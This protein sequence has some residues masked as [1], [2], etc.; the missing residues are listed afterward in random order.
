MTLATV[1]ALATHAVH[2]HSRV[3]T[4]GVSIVVLAGEDDTEVLVGVAA[5]RLSPGDLVVVSP[6]SDLTVTPLPGS[7]ALYAELPAFVLEPWCPLS[8][9]PAV[10]RGDLARVAAGALV[11]LHTDPPAD[12]AA[13]A[14]VLGALAR[15]LAAAT[16]GARP[17]VPPDTLLRSRILRHIDTAIRVGPVA[18]GD[19]A[20]RFGISV[21]KLHQLFAGRSRSFMQTVMD[22]RA[23]WCALELRTI[24]DATPAALA[25]RWGFADSSHFERAW[26]RLD[27][28]AAG[29]RV[30][31]G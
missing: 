21:R 29:G 13:L 1:A 23:H 30:H 14:D 16:A 22:R 24:A 19:T 28:S 20:R 4:D 12:P 10:A 17:D 11:A 9:N 26:S 15:L 25:R 27:P 2:D 3:V 6:G 31:G 8:E 18:P 5:I 7:R